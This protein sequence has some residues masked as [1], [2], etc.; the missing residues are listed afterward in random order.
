MSPSS[1]I[2]KNN[3][4]KIGIRLTIMSLGS[5]LI[6]FLANQFLNRGI[7]WK[8]LLLSLPSTS[9]QTKW[10]YVSTDSAFSIFL[11]QEALFVDIRNREDFEI[12]HIPNALSLPFISYFNNSE[13]FYQQNRD[14]TFILYDLERNSKDVRLVAR[15]VI[16]DKFSSVYILRG[17]FVEWLDRTYPVEGGHFE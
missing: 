17:G 4:W 11:Q 1:L 14:A 6:G 15:Q 16:K 9:E 7:H 3:T 2:F 8:I 12:D 10:H 13:Q 5:L